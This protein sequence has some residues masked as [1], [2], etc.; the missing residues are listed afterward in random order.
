M[1]TTLIIEVAETNRSRAKYTAWH[2][3]TE[4]ATDTTQPLLDGARVLLDRGIAKP[5]DEIRMVT[6]GH[7]T[8]RAYGMAGV[9]AGLSVC[10]YDGFRSY[11]GVKR[12]LG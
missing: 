1:T 3:D 4:I 8:T 10:E 7:G 9:L 12:A 2:D 11:R 6:Q 5:D